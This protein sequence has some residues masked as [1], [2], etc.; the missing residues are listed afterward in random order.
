M[1]ITFDSILQVSRLS[2]PLLH[3]CRALARKLRCNP[4]GSGV[5]LLCAVAITSILVPKIMPFS[6]VEVVSNSFT[7]I[8]G[9]MGNKEPP[10]VRDLRKKV[11]DLRKQ[12]DV[13]QSALDRVQSEVDRQKKVLN[14]QRKSL[15]EH[16]LKFD[17]TLTAL[18]EAKSAELV[19]EERFRQQTELFSKCRD[20]LDAANQENATLTININKLQ[21]RPGHLTDE[22]VKNTLD[23]LYHR[24][25]LWVQH[26]FLRPSPEDKSLRQQ[27]GSTFSVHARNLDIICRAQ[28][29]ISCRIYN[30]FLSR[31]MVAIGNLDILNRFQS[32]DQ[33]VEEQCTLFCMEAYHS[34]KLVLNLPY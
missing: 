17:K 29:S 26:H 12:L 9:N 7:Q 8:M 6:L 3:L 21:Q 4:R 19:A 34:I 14:D 24:L 11:Q 30:D 25:D 27:K 13:R 31:H 23:A 16:D 33:Q 5:G 2:Q 10:V 20:E 32:I 15:D 22:E 18:R 28:S 1:S